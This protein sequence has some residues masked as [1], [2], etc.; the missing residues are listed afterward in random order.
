MFLTLRNDA[1]Q[2]NTCKTVDKE[3]LTFPPK[4]LNKYTKEKFSNRQ[5]IIG[6]I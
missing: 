3:L 4:N 6:L 1:F 2:G 5:I